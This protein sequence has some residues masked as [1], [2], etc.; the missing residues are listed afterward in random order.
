MLKNKKKDTGGR[1]CRPSEKVR[2]A[3]HEREEM[4]HRHDAKAQRDREHRRHHL[5]LEE[6]SENEDEEYSDKERDIKEDEVSEEEDCGT[7]VGHADIPSIAL[8]KGLFQ[9][10]RWPVPTKLSA[11]P[12]Q[13]LMKSNSRIPRAGSGNYPD[14]HNA[15]SSLLF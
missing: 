3:V 13:H 8:T 1:V 5:L 7:Q 12:R 4:V 11:A 10:S 2:Q 6:G 9:F 14:H 15:V